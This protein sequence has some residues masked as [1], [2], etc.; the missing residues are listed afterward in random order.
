MATSVEADTKSQVNLKV[1][2]DGGESASETGVVDVYDDPLIHNS[3]RKKL[4]LK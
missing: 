1:A 4:D 2:N 3:I